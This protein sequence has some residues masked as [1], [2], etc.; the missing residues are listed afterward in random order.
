MFLLV[1]ASVWA[2][3]A[4]GGDLANAVVDAVKMG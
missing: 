4:D 2:N 1:L 3:G